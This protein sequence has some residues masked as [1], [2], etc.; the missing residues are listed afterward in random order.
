M[1]N[2]FSLSA[3][4]V[5]PEGRAQDLEAVTMWTGAAVFLLLPVIFP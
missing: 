4:R 1:L 3:A 2:S 5:W